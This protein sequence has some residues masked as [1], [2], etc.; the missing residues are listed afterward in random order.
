MSTG[1]EDWGMLHTELSATS[2]KQLQTHLDWGDSNDQ[3]ASVCLSSSEE[4]LDE[5]SAPGAPDCVAEVVA[6]TMARL[7]CADSKSLAADQ[8]SS[9]ADWTTLQPTPVAAEVLRKEGCLVLE[10]MLPVAICDALRAEVDSALDSAIAAHADSGEAFG[11]V[12]VRQNRWDMHLRETGV[13]AEALRTVRVG[14]AQ[15]LRGL[16]SADDADVVPT[17]IELSS[18]ISDPGAPRQP[19]HPDVQ[20]DS[21]SPQYTVFV[22]LQDTTAEM[23]PTLFL[24]QTV[25]AQRIR[26]NSSSLRAPRRCP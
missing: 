23:G 17:L 18:L 21:G 12:L 1:D 8:Q 24:P 19:I 4:L 15:V 5:T 6:A 11:S 7:Q 9:L 14:V 25:R 13:V 10:G 20:F 3:C 2:I 16:L 22:A 26:Y